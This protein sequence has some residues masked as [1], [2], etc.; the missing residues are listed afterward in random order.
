MCMCVCVYI[1]IYIYIHTYIHTYTYTCMHRYIHTYKHTYKK[2]KRHI[3]TYTQTQ[4]ERVCMPVRIQ[5]ACISYTPIASTATCNTC[6]YTYIHTKNKKHT[7]KRIHK[8]NQ[9]GYVCL[10][11]LKTRASPTLPS[12]AQ[13]RAT[14]VQLCAY[15]ALWDALVSDHCVCVSVCICVVTCNTCATMCA[16]GSVGCSCK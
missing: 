13:Q 7:Y 9:N 6:A 4:S 1:Y 5:N 16:Q 15:K 3:Q 10:S 2:Q 14:L 8:H 11:E 12:P